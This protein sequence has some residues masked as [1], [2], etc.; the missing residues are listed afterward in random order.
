MWTVCKRFCITKKEKKKKRRTK[1]TETSTENNRSKARGR[2]RRRR[3]VKK[4]SKAIKQSQNKK[5][6][7]A[8]REEYYCVR[9][10]SVNHEESCSPE[11]QSVIRRTQTKVIHGYWTRASYTVFTL[12]E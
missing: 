10:R 2:R 8:E 4:H 7:R 12:I 11:L 6:E 3:K 5:E 9:K 1:S